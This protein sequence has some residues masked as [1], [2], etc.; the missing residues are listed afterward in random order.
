MDSSHDHVFVDS[1]SSLP[2]AVVP[3]VRFQKLMSAREVTSK[4]VERAIGRIKQ[5]HILWSVFKL[6]MWDSLNEIVCVCYMLANAG[7]PLVF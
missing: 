2:E 6:C 7:P 5:F 4:H 1:L 3:E